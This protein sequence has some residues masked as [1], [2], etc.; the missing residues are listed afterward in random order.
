MESSVQPCRLASPSPRLKVRIDGKKV[1]SSGKA[2]ME[3]DT[4]CAQTTLSSCDVAVVAS[5]NHEA[6]SHQK[7]IFDNYTV[8][9]SPSSR[10]SGDE[11]GLLLPGF[12]ELVL[13]AFEL[14]ATNSGIS[15]RNDEE[16]AIT[17]KK[18]E[19]KEETEHEIINL[20]NTVRVLREREKNL[21]IQLLE[22]HGLK[23]QDAIVTELQNRLRIS[24]TESKL[25]TL[26]I[27]SLQADNKSLEVQVA[28][29]ARVIS[30]LESARAQ[31]KLLKREIRSDAEQYREQ[32][33]TLKQRVANLQDQEQNATQ[34]DV[35][36]QKKLQRLEDLEDELTKLKE[37]NSRLWCE[38]S[39]LARKLESTQI[40][41][42]SVL[43][44][45]EVEALHEDNHRLRQENEDLKNELERL[46]TG[47]YADVEELVYLRWVNA[48]LRY[49]LRNYQPHGKTVARDLSKTL[50]PKSE[51]KVKQLVLEYANSE[52]I[53]EKSI[54]VDFDAEYWS[55]S[56]ASNN[57]ECGDFDDSSCDISSAT[58]TNSSSKRKFF[59][60]LK[61]LV[62]GNSMNNSEQTSSM[63]RNPVSFTA[64]GRRESVS[65]TTFEDMMGTYS[66]DTLSPHHVSSIVATPL[67]ATET[68][69][70]GQRNRIL[71]SQG[72][73]RNSLDIQR[74]RNLP[75]EDASE[76]EC[77]RSNSDLGS[78]WGNKVALGNGSAFVLAQ[79]D[80]FVHDQD[81]IEKL[82]FMKLAEIL[83]SSHG[84]QT[85]HRKAASF[86][87]H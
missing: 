44:D 65:T 73:S 71:H 64:S 78:S 3:D 10:H 68:R 37:D 46:Q 72:S 58:K 17:F 27:E 29:Y 2:G 5:Q 34:I 86:S 9:L 45:P 50:S 16:T 75:L 61:N 23:E 81:T 15:P 19:N 63:D 84:T 43:E 7:I 40:L 55:S 42:S 79:E 59:R 26:K 33:Y 80:Q 48:C 56:Q 21:E 51:E 13:K 28:D 25:L 31:L 53:R 6:Q 4:C 18:A 67:R 8:G 83:N 14:P 69:N 85:S 22:Y 60:K 32:L 24:N 35:D 11:E 20:R 76:V 41:A 38:N 77:L 54:P 47:R 39:E 1:N 66:C 62:L 49:E 30:E 57:T 12:N 74:S 36:I 87:C 70:Y 52:G 82:E